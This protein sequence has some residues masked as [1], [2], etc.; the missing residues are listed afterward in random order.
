MR[1]RKKR[2]FICRVCG[3]QIIPENFTIPVSV[4]K[5]YVRIFGELKRVPENELHNYVGFTVVWQ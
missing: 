4:K 3:S 1:K 2:G 5:P